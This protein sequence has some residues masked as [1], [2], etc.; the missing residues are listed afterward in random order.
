MCA[1]VVENEG[2]LPSIVIDQEGQSSS[3]ELGGVEKTRA[4]GASGD[5]FVVTPQ[6]MR[7]AAEYCPG[8]LLHNMTAL[9]YIRNWPLVKTIPEPADDNHKRILYR[10]KRESAR[11]YVERAFGVLK[12]KWA[13]LANPTRAL[14]KERIVNMMKPTVTDIEKLYWHHEKSTG[15]IRNWPLV[16]TIPE[17]ADDDHKRILYREKRESARKYVE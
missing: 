10:E 6:K 3:G 14:K 12:K 4:L 1:L 16:K 11:K 7:V 5:I 2:G 8:A 9:G 13:V 15:Y 17:P